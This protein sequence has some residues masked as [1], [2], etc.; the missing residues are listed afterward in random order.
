MILFCF[1]TV[2]SKYSITMRNHTI[3]LPCKHMAH[4]NQ[5]RIL[6]Q[7]FVICISVSSR[8]RSWMPVNVSV[9]YSFDVALV[10]LDFSSKLREIYFSLRSPNPRHS[11]H[12]MKHSVFPHRN[13]MRKLFCYYFSLSNCKST[14]TKFNFHRNEW[15]AFSIWILVSLHFIS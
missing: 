9:A 11:L 6:R 12:H 10:W 8:L 7:L 1:C 15:F 13:R 14:R 5:L 3:V 4:V 2:Q